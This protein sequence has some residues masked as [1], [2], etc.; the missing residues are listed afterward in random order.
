[1]VKIELPRKKSSV[2]SALFKVTLNISV[3]KVKRS[4]RFSDVL[5]NDKK[6]KSDI[7]V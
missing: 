6:N 7:W 3:F 4:Q 5:K 1:M 2:S